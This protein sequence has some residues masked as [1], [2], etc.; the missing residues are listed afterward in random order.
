MHLPGLAIF[1]LLMVKKNI[2]MFLV[3]SFSF[4]LPLAAILHPT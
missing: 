1:M 3:W 4:I 2:E